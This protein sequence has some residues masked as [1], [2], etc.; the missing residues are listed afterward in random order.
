MYGP[1]TTTSE[2]VL[3]EVVFKAR[4][5]CTVTRSRPIALPV[6]EGNMSEM[7]IEHFK[8]FLGQLMWPMHEMAKKLRVCLS[9]LM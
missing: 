8:L 1:T 9:M 2:W 3:I 7:P 5:A 4:G 6:K